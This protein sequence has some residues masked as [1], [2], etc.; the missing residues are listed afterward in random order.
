MTPANVLLVEDNP[1][2][3]LLTKRALDRALKARGVNYTIETVLDGQQ[4]LDRL[5]DGRRL[6]SPSFDLVLLDL[7]LPVLDGQDT[8]R[9]IRAHALGHHVPVVVLTTSD[10]RVDVERAWKA[11][12]QAYVVKPGT[13]NGGR[14]DEVL[15]NLGRVF[16]GMNV[17][18]A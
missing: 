10:N 1:A 5:F 16:L 2:D 14:F 6:R 12:I 17:R 15:D 11:S 4:A 18:A 9:H 13:N 8:L 3:Q 7:W